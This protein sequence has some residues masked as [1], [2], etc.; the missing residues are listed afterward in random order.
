MEVCFSF[1]R[2]HSSYEINPNILLTARIR[3]SITALGDEPLKR[4]KGTIDVKS[5]VINKWKTLN[6]DAGELYI[7]MLNPRNKP[8][9]TIDQTRKA[10]QILADV[11]EVAKQV[12]S[13]DSRVRSKFSA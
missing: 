5:E 2:H 13:V 11:D 3:K 6:Q 8:L 4:L 7:T 1:I 12:E 9:T 10:E